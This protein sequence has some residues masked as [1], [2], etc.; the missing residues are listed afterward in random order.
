[1]RKTARRPRPAPMNLNTSFQRP[2]SL[3]SSMSS[4]SSSARL[5]PRYEFKANTG[6]F[7][8]SREEAVNAF[9]SRVRNRL[10]VVIS[11][12]KILW[13]WSLLLASHEKFSKVWFVIKL[14]SR[15][16]T[17]FTCFASSRSRSH[18]T[19]VRIAT[20]SGAENL[21]R[22]HWHS[23]SFW[24]HDLNSNFSLDLNSRRSGSGG[25][26][27]IRGFDHENVQLVGL[28]Q[29]DIDGIVYKNI[30]ERDFTQYGSGFLGK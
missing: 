6:Q 19:F 2:P 7:L 1:M 5:K 25:F 27:H 24:I 4:N 23:F 9:L 20:K 28:G 16:K 26:A 10:L 3:N 22:P 18:R 21:R 11:N 17:I 30:T 29:V 13:L 12:N 15:R 14:K 8:F